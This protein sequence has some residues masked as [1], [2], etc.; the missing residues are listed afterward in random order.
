MTLLRSYI[1]DG[2]EVLRREV[3]AFDIRSAVYHY[4]NRTT[5]CI[6][7]EWIL[8]HVATGATLVAEVKLH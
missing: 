3:S 2:T 8:L 4:S 7:S 6:I 5:A 1:I